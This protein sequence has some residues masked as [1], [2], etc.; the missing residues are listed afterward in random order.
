MEPSPK[1]AS[2]LL[3]TGSTGRVGGAL[4]AIWAG[5]QAC[6][7]PI[8]WHGRKAGPDVDLVWDIGQNPPVALPAGLIVLHLAGSTSG[9][10]GALAQNAVVTAAV[11]TAA[12]KAGARHVF[13]MSSAAVYQP[14]PNLL[15]EDDTTAPLSPYGQAKRDAEVAAQ[16]CLAD[17]SLIVL[18]LANLAGADALFGACLPGRTVT[19]D[20]VPGQLRGPE[21]SYIGPHAL[22][23]V[24]SGLVLHVMRGGVLP[25]VLNLAQ[26]GIMAMADLLDARGQPWVFGPPRPASIARVALAT[27]RLSAVVPLVPATPAGLVA[28]LDLVQGWPR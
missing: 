6:G 13:V 21:R 8:L 25:R 5:N 23:Q 3:V 16:D 26:P 24:L 12:Q 22:A 1:Q 14:S 28:D 20:P 17:G 27:D 11:C 19:L 15:A 18:R 2:G 10:P 4:R 9:S 7:L